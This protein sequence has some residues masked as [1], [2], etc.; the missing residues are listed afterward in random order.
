MGDDMDDECLFPHCCHMDLEMELLKE[1]SDLAW[2][3]AK[4]A[5]QR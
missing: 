3:E 2:A 5:P 1:I 4:D